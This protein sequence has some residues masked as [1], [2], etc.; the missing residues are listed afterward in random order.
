MIYSTNRTESLGDVTIS[1]N[2]NYFGAGYL[3]FVQECY[4]DEQAIFESC[5]K[6]DIDECLVKESTDLE[7]LNEAFVSKAKEQLAK[8]MQKF[9]EWI[10]S[11]KKSVM[12]KFDTEFSKAV[13]YRV[14]DLQKKAKDLNADAKYT[15]K[16]FDST[17][18]LEIGDKLFNNIISCKS[19]VT[20]NPTKEDV[21]KIQDFLKTVK[22]MDKKS[23]IEDGLTDV[24]DFDAKKVIDDQ[25]KII[26][27]TKGIISTVR[28]TLDQEKAVANQLRKEAK[29]A[30][31]DTE[32]KDAAALKLQAASAYRTLCV[33]TFKVSMKLVRS[34]IYKALGVMEAAIKQNKKAVKEGTEV[35]EEFDM[36][37]I[38]FEAAMY[39]VEA[40]LED[41]TEGKDCDDCCD[42]DNSDDKSDDEE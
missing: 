26:N 15:G 18:P 37:D 35:V 32:D 42:D 7:A 6:A 20:G 29:K 19:I 40:S 34:I 3:D 38:I 21:E 22:E 28:S 27:D 16:A 17:A 25:V 9:I 8:M 39:E 5:I 36:S 33:E 24:K 41:F 12:K 30:G 2:E 4:E 10:E 11:V 13:T 1:A 23:S 14:K 31:K